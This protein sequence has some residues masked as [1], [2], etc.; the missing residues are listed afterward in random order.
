MHLLGVATSSSAKKDERFGDEYIEYLEKEM[1]LI[2]KHLG[3]AQEGAP[4][5]L[6]AAARR[7]FLNEAQIERLYTAT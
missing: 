3:L 5:A 7:R 2:Y 4:V 6:G 1:G